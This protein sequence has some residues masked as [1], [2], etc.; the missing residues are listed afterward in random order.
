[1]ADGLV[2]LFV[3]LGAMRPKDEQRSIG[4]VRRRLSTVHLQKWQARERPK[5][6]TR[7][8]QFRYVN[9]GLA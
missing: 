9:Q 4:L 5:F 3:A 6:S 8:R 7:E 1:V 2:A